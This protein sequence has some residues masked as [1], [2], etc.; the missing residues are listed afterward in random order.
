MK[1][2]TYWRSS[3][4]YRVRIALQLKGLDYEDAYIHLVRDGGEQLGEAYGAINPQKLVPS[5]ELDDGAVM[6]Q[7]LAM[8]EYLEEVHPEPALLPANPVDRARARALAQAVACDIHPVNNLRILKYLSGELQLDED[9]KAAW[10]RHW[11]QTGFEALEKM[12]KDSSGTGRFCH[13]DKPGL[14]DCC[15]VP[16]V[17]NA[18]R[19]EVD[20]A[21]YP[22]IAR[23]DGAC[24]ELEAFQKAA[25]ERQGDAV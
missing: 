25:P 13:G 19:F 22:T 23:I 21:A 4:A 20:M 24:L 9:R 15:L 16:Q 18:R 5:L 8:I 6:T 17:Y 3:A 12:L 2:Y 1:L 11:V 10:Y 7:S 14:A